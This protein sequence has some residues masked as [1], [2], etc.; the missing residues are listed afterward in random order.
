MSEFHIELYSQK[1]SGP[2]E[3]TVILPDPPADDPTSYYSGSRKYKVLWLFH[4]GLNGGRDWIRNSNIA[5]YCK[6]RNVIAVIPNAPNSDFTNHPEYADGFLFRDF[7]FE[8]L[9]PMVQNWLPASKKAEDNFLSGYSMGCQAV[10]VYGALHPDLFGGLIPLSSPPLDYSYL[11]PYRHLDSIAFR[12]AA[13]EDPVTFHAAYGPP[14]GLHTKELN[15]I[16]KHPTVGDFLDSAE[17]S[18]ARFID[19]AK[20]GAVP[21]VYLPG[22]SGDRGLLAFKEHTDSLGLDC[23]TYDL[24]DAPSHDFSFWDAAIQR[25]MDFFGLK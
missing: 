21:P 11:E 4:G 2:T 15:L 22:S 10:Y 1:L 8:E 5:R 24:T 3:V 23:I 13:A 9:M 25:G 18:R 14:A 20:V 16:A 12:R 19:A 7:F 6:E 17:H